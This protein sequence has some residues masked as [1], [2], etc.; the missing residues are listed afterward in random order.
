MALNNVFPIV[1]SVAHG[2]WDACENILINIGNAL[3]LP[4]RHPEAACL[5][6][7]VCHGNDIASV[8]SMQSLH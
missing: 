4:K 8:L 1:Q 3:P 2:T 6:G 7:K 5:D